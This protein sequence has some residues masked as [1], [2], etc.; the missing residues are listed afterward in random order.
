MEILS[1]AC[2]MFKSTKKKKAVTIDIA[3]EKKVSRLFIFRFLWVIPIIVPFFVYNIWF[4]ILSIV[5]FF[6]M[7]IFGER[8]KSL[9]EKQMHFVRYVVA[10]QAYTRFFT[11]ARPAVLPWN[12]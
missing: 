2:D 8:S 1:P 9:F 7:L 4:S 10:W 12:G 5:Q 6:H 3:F 11:N